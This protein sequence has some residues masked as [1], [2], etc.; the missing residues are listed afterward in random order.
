M[1]I[2]TIE[3]KALRMQGYEFPGFIRAGMWIS[4][5]RD[6]N[7]W[8]HEKRPVMQQDG[9]TSDGDLIWLNSPILEFV[10][11]TIRDWRLSVRQKPYE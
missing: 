5:D 6:G 8:A 1:S 7:W 2:A 3:P 10:P 4:Q 9:W 11:P